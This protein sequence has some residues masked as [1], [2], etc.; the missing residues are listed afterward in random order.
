MKPEDWDI[1]IDGLVFDNHIAKWGPYIFHI[2]PVMLDNQ[3][4]HVTVENQDYVVTSKQ[5]CKTMTEARHR[6]VEL[7]LILESSV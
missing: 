5:S 3:Y 7:V 2:V 4:L 1:L 6:L